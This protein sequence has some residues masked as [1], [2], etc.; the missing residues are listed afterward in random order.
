MLPEIQGPVV[1]APRDPGTHGGCSQRSRDPWWMLPE[2]QGPM[3]AGTRDGCSQRFRDLW[4]MLPEIQGPVVDAPR[5][6]GTPGGRDTWWM[7]PEIQGPVL[8]GTRGGCSQKSR[9][10]VLV[11]AFAAATAVPWTMS[12]PSDGH[13]SLDGSARLGFPG[14]AA[15][16]VRVQAVLLCV[17]RETVLKAAEVGG[18]PGG[19]WLPSPQWLLL[20]AL[21]PR[22]C[23]RPPPLLPGFGLV[24]V[25][26]G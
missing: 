4:W 24:L 15:T 23:L 10:L 7:L 17:C 9:F 16:P 5:D 21:V 19:Q 20:T 26:Q 6:P 1:D 13:P 2:I 25:A 12:S 14:A 22:V 8:A 18:E 11:E 3:V